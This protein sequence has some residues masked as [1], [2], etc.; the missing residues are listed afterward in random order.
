MKKLILILSAGTFATF[1]I[2]VLLGRKDLQVPCNHT[3][4]DEDL[5]EEE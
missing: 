5:F 4:T 2:C 1:L 3:S